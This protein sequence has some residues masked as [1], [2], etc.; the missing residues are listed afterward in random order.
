MFALLP[1]H[2][3]GGQNCASKGVEFD[4][5]YTARDNYELKRFPGAL[6]GI[7]VLMILTGILH[8]C[9]VH[10]FACPTEHQADH[11]RNAYA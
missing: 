1:A 4:W 10:S 7:G 8:L 5:D 11:S 9:G 6:Q 3:C 2:V